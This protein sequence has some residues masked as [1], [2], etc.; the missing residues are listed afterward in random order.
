MRA[1]AAQEAVQEVAHAVILEARDEEDA[2]ME[3]EQDGPVEGAEA[4]DAIP[5]GEIPQDG[6]IQA[7]IPPGEAIPDEAEA[8]ADA[9]VHALI[10]IPAT[11]ERGLQLRVAHWF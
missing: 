10:T 7:V 11:P 6:D 3:T 9:E 4:V 8:A 2:G 1:K 5:L